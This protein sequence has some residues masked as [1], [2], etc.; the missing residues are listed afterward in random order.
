MLQAFGF[1]WRQSQWAIDRL[2]LATNLQ[3]L[4]VYVLAAVGL[5]L[6][7]RESTRHGSRYQPVLVLLVAPALIWT[8]LIHQSDSEH[9]DIHAIT[10]S[11][12]FALG[13]AWLVFVICCWLSTR[14]GNLWTLFTGSWIGYWRFLWQVQYLLRAYPNLRW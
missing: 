13:W 3:H 11:A 6:L 10:W 8:V 2:S 7:L 9:P 4:A 5:V 14:L 12:G 1:A